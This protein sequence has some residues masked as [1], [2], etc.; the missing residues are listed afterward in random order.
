[1]SSEDCEPKGFDRTNVID[2]D[3]QKGAAK[4]CLVWIVG[5]VVG[6]AWEQAV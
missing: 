4:T 6:R 2:A 5:G 1:M 3:N